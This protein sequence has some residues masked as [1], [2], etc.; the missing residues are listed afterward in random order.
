M[1]LITKII[2]TWRNLNKKL[3]GKISFKKFILGKAL[4]KMKMDKQKE[5]I[6]KI[7]IL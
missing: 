4:K 3:I 2:I 5:F 6:K 1:K 7:E